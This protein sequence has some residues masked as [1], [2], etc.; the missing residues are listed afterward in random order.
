MFEANKPHQ[1]AVSPKDTDGVAK[2]DTP[3][4]ITNGP[5]ELDDAAPVEA[6]SLLRH[7]VDRTAR[8]P[9]PIH[10]RLCVTSSSGLSRTGALQTASSLTFTSLLG[11]VPIIAVFLAIL[12]AFPALEGAREQVKEMIL[13]PLAPGAGE[14]VRDP[15]ETYP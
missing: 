11:L 12:S 1:E 10:R 4:P 8:G 3:L 5:A 7:R 9:W 14:T 13:A 2:G 6:K 15:L